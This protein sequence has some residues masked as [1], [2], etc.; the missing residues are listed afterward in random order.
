M[1]GQVLPFPASLNR[2]HIHVFVFGGSTGESI[3]VALPD[4]GWV[5]VDGCKVQIGEEEAF[6]SLDLYERLRSGPEDR[7][8]LL[9]WTHPH[10]DHYLGIRETIERHLPLRVGM[11]MVVAPAPGS[12]RKEMEALGNHPYLPSDLALQDVFSRVLST[13]ERVRFHWEEYPDSRYFLSSAVEVIAL[14]E[15]RI[16]ACSPELE[17]LREFFN[18]P[19]PSLSKTIKSRANEFSTVLAIQFAHT[20][21]I[22]GADL[23]F[24]VGGRPIPHGWTMVA[25]AFPESSK[26]KMFKVSHHGSAEAIPAHF[27]QDQLDSPEWVVTPFSTSGLPRFDDGAQGGLHHMLG[28]VDSIRLTSTSGLERPESPGAQ[29]SRR[30][31]AQAFA[32]AQTGGFMAGTPRAVAASSFDFGWGFQLD[33]NGKVLARFA[34]AQAVTVVE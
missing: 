11:A 23:P 1:T 19:I 28:R 20:Q 24:S 3:A 33:R 27:Q 34:G 4:R 14:R 8:E 7:I 9:A 2:S 31:L 26:H 32:R 5:L 22:L 30:S 15:V 10:N 17:S 25:R 29:I 12:A 13:I 21:I 18:Q 6:P 16:A